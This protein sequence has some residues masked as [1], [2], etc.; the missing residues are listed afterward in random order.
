MKT[1]AVYLSKTDAHAVFGFTEYNSIRIL[2]YWQS[3]LTN[4][5]YEALFSEIKF[6]ALVTN[7]YLN[8]KSDDVKYAIQVVINKMIAD[9]Y[10]N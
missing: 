5:T 2:R 9:I 8:Y 6:M 10:P 4:E 1:D 3:L 7:V